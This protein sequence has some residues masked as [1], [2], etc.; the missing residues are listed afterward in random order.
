MSLSFKKLLVVLL[1]EIMGLDCNIDSVTL[2]NIWT[3]AGPPTYHPHP[4]TPYALTRRHLTQ[5]KSSQQTTT[6]IHFYAIKV[7]PKPVPAAPRPS[8][9]T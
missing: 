4:L 3:G 7:V 8:R 9:S 2:N 6:P 1:Q 5:N